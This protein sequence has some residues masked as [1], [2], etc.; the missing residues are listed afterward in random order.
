MKINIDKCK[1]IILQDQNVNLGV[2]PMENV[3]KF[4]SLGSLILS[5]GLDIDRRIGLCTKNKVFH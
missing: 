3:N 1:V 4:I 5:R 2:E